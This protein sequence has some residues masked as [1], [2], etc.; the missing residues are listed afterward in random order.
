MTRFLLLLAVLVPVALAQ[1]APR[2]AS[3]VAVE[4][5]HAGAQAFVDGDMARAEQAV[6][7]GLRAAPNNA[8]LRALRDLIEQDQDEQDQQQG[9]RG[10]DDAQNESGSEEGEEGDQG[11]GGQNP[12][13]P[14]PPDG[15]EA[16]QDQTRTQPQDPGQQ[17]GGPGGRGDRQGG[18]AGDEAEAVPQGE[19]SQ[20]QAERI[21][22][23]VGGEERLLLRELRRAPTRSRRADKDW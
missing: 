5:Y 6:D 7:A 1:R 14:P 9:G 20:A 4:R 8:R 13:Q 19:M 17:Q 2:G 23:A 22:D 18:Q 15:P 11:Q 3:D 21:L 16:E 10:S 12:N